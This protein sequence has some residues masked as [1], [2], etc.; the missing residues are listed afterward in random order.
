VV[1]FLPELR[2]AWWVVRG[3]LAVQ[4]AA[5]ALTP[6]FAGGGLRFPLPELFGSRVLGLLATAAAVDGSVRLGRQGPGGVRRRALTLVADAALGLL[7]LAMLLQ[8]GNTGAAGDAGAAYVLVAS[9]NDNELLEQPELVDR[10]GNEVA[11]RYP[12]AQRHF[13]PDSGQSTPVPGPAFR[14]PPGPV[15]PPGDPAGSS[16]AGP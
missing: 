6:L 9:H 7:G 14:P 4:A 16:G 12:R 1:E 13:D 8:L 10:D 11:N 5:V 3:Y 15:R 2:P